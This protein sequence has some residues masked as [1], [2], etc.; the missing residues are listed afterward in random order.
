MQYDPNQRL[1]RAFVTEERLKGLRKKQNRN[2]LRWMPDVVQRSVLA[3]RLHLLCKDDLW[4][5]PRL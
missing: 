4:D 5:D 3:E 2:S 1:K